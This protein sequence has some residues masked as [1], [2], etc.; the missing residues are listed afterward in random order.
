M[1]SAFYILKILFYGFIFKYFS[2]LNAKS[3]I[4]TVCLEYLC[5]RPQN[6][7]PRCNAVG[8]ACK[9]RYF[10]FRFYYG[11]YVFKSCL[12]NILADTARFIFL[13]GFACRAYFLK[14]F[15]KLKL[16]EHT[17]QLLCRHRRIYFILNFGQLDRCIFYDFR[18]SSAHICRILCALKLCFCC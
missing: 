11:D 16:F 14:Y 2:E 3:V 8:A 18:K 15:Y 10:L 17:A 4:R 1:H 13:T 12:F 5:T 6:A 7:P 9:N